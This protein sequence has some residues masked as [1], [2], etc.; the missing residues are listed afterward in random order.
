M[1]PT[2]EIRPHEFTGASMS[3]PCDA[4]G[5]IYSAAAH[6]SQ[7]S[8][9]MRERA[10]SVASE[11]TER[12]HRY[13]N[14]DR[15]K[16]AM[17]RTGDPCGPIKGLPQ[18]FIGNLIMPFVATAL[19]DASAPRAPVDLRERQYS[20]DLWIDEE[21]NANF[22]FHITGGSFTDARHALEKFIACLQNKLTRGE[23][24]PYSERVSN[25]CEQCGKDFFYSYE[26]TIC[27]TCFGRMKETK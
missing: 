9:E 8:N 10:Q 25:H 14:H 17:Q 13:L 21:G 20:G 12:L 23:E 2:N 22:K 6:H 1:E 24:C 15:I 26:A 3:E 19:A 16:H 11:I 18:E 27:P 7:V 4:C 5:L